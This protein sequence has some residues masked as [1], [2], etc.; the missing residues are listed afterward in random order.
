[1][2][3][4]WHQEEQ[5]LAGG[6]GHLGETPQGR[7]GAASELAQT[8]FPSLGSCVSG[9]V[10]GIKQALQ[11]GARDSYNPAL[12]RRQ[13]ARGDRALSG[14]HPIPVAHPVA[15][16]LRPVSCVLAGLRAPTEPQPCHQAQRPRVS[17]IRAGFPPPAVTL[18]PLQDGL[19]KQ[20]LLPPQCTPQPTPGFRTCPPSTGCSQHFPSPLLMLTHTPRV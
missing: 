11:K 13:E 20:L 18:W 8:Y 12:P 1:M 6:S 2:Q 14:H 4:D 17:N 5:H 7:L 19:Q 10:R 3:G 15:R 9:A 16:S